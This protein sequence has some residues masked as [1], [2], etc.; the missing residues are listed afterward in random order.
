MQEKTILEIFNWTKLCQQRYKKKFKELLSFTNTSLFFLKINEIGKNI[1]IDFRIYLGGLR[2]TP[3][4]IASLFKN[5]PVP[6]KIN[7]N[8]N[9]IIHN[10]K[11]LLILETNNRTISEF[12]SALWCQIWILNRKEKIKRVHFQRI[13]LPFFD[14]EEK[15]SDYIDFGKNKINLL[16]LDKYLKNHF[17]LGLNLTQDIKNPNIKIKTKSVVFKDISLRMQLVKIEF[18]SGLYE[19][20][21]SKK[22]KQKSLKESYFSPNNL[23]FLKNYSNKNVMDTHNLKSIKRKIPIF[24]FLYKKN[25][26]ISKVN[27]KLSRKKNNNY[28]FKIQ[29]RLMFIKKEYNISFYSPKAS[30]VT[31]GEINLLKFT[32]KGELFLFEF[33][34]PF[35]FDVF[36][37]QQRLSFHLKF[38]VAF[39][40]ISSSFYSF[41]ASWNTQYLERILL[42]LAKFSKIKSSV[43]YLTSI[44]CYTNSFTLKKINYK[45]K[46]N[47]NLIRILKKNIHFNK[48]KSTWTQAGIEICS[49]S[50]KLMNIL[51]K[52]K[53]LTY[54]NLDFNFN[55]KPIR[56]LSTKE[57]KKSRFS[58]TFHFLREFLRFV[59]LIVDCH[60]K[61]YSGYIDFFQLLD[62]IHFILTH[63]GK[64]TGIYRYKYKIMK[65]IKICKN[66]KKILY[67]KFYEYPVSK[68][69]GF[70]F[71]SPV[72]KVWV[73]FIK[74]MV[75][76]Q[77]RWLANLLSRH[78]NGRKYSKKSF[79]ITKQRKDGY[80][81]VELKLAL[82]NELNNL[83]GN[84]YKKTNLKKYIK[85]SNEAWKSWKSNNNWNPIDLPD[86]IENLILDYVKTKSIWWVKSACLVRESL[87][88]GISMEKSKIKKNLG[89]I[90]RLWFKAEQKRQLD[91]LKNGPF[92]SKDELF[93]VSEIFC[94][95]I[96]ICQIKKINFPSFKNKWDL[97]LL[98]LSLDR[99]KKNSPS[100]KMD[101]KINSLE[102]NLLQT[103]MINP[104]GTFSGIKNSILTQRIFSEIG[105]AFMDGFSYLNPI[106]FIAFAERITDGYIDQYLWYDCS[107]KI[108]FPK[109]IKPSD[110]E[111][112]PY[113]I[114]KFQNIIEKQKEIENFSENHSLRIGKIEFGESSDICDLILMEKTLRK[115]LNYSL[116]SYICS[117]NNV[118]VVFKDMFE[119]NSMGILRG[120]QFGGFLIQI[121]YFVFDLMILGIKNSLQLFRNKVNDF[122]KKGSNLFTYY[123]RYISKTIFII[124]PF[125]FCHTKY[126]TIKMSFKIPLSMGSIN[127]SVIL[128]NKGLYQT[129]NKNISLGF[130][131]FSIFFI[132]SFKLI[133]D[134]K[135]M[136]E[137]EKY[138]NM[139][140]KI[141]KS[142]M[143]SL[144]LFQVEGRIRQIILNSGSTTFTKIANKWNS[145]ILGILTY[146]RE[147]SKKNRNCFSIL[148]KS[149]EK[150]QNRIKTS[151]NSKMP[152][153]FPLVLFFAPKELGGLGMLS[154]S[155]FLIPDN[156]LKH[157]KLGQINENLNSSFQS[158]ITSIPVIINFIKNWQ[159]EFED[160]KEIWSD[161]V[162]RRIF[163]KHQQRNLTFE[164]I[165]DLWNKGIP[166]INTLFQ[167]EREL[168]AFDYGWRLRTIMEKF[169]I[170]KINPFWWTV[171]NHDGRLWTLEFYKDEMIKN[172]GGITNILEHTLFK[173]TY[174]PTWE[175]LFWE[176]SS[177]FEET[178][179]NKK[180]THAQRSG[181][182]QI[183][184]RRFTLWWSPTI[185]RGNIYI[186]FQVQLDLTGVFMHGKIPTLKISLIQI[187]RAHLWQKIHQSITLDLCRSLEIDLDKLMISSIQKEQVHPRKSYKM[188]SSCADIIFVSKRSWKI[189]KPSLLTP[190]VSKFKSQCDIGNIFWVDIQLRWGDFDSHD[191]ER[192]VRGKF[193]DFTVYQNGLYPGK[194]GLIIGIDLSY[195]I[196]S[197]YGF[198]IFGL[199]QK[200]WTDLTKLMKSNSAL[201]ILRDRIR[202]GL[203]LYTS[204]FSESNLNSGNYFELFQSGNI[205][206]I[207]D[208]LFYRVT[209]HQTLIG[210]VKTKPINGVIIIFL[211]KNGNLILRIISSEIWKQQKRLS[212]LARWRA[213]EEIF[214]FL[215][216]ISI[217]DKPDQIILLRKTLIDPL[218]I[219]LIEY[220]NILIKF[221]NFKISFQS[222]LYFKKIT[223]RILGANECETVIFNL[224]DNW[225]DTVS[226][227]TAFSRLILILKGLEVDCKQIKQ[228]LGVGLEKNVKNFFWP[229]FTNEE[230]IT[231]EITLKDLIL[232]SFATKNKIDSASLFQTEI[233]DIIFGSYTKTPDLAKNEETCLQTVL[234]SDNTGKKITTTV[235]STILKNNGMIVSLK[236]IFY[237]IKEM[238]KLLK[239]IEIKKFNKKS[240]FEC[241]V[242]PRNLLKKL[243]FNPNIILT[244]ISIIFGKN[245]NSVSYVMEI[246]ILLLIPQKRKILK[247]IEWIP[248]RK[249]NIFKAV[250]FLG[251]VI[252]RERKANTKSIYNFP[253]RIL[254]FMQKIL[255]LK[256]N[257]LLVYIRIEEKKISL[258]CFKYQINLHF[259]T[260]TPILLTRKFFGLVI[261]ILNWN[262]L[263]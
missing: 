49:Q 134:I 114:N 222:L 174:F 70:G 9:L 77:E 48:V 195:N 242:F 27:L 122:S 212:Q 21:F 60:V 91:Y 7:E 261:N 138:R 236:K 120:L 46:M 126:L 229:F 88:K 34:K 57:R 254:N 151:F 253:L 123:N 83:K 221:S 181:L 52:R 136:N 216:T 128:D 66:I 177:G 215:K 205:W 55:L 80:L 98:I 14:D 142:K 209:V 183:P 186:G 71:W 147:F 31:I 239:K 214:K 26:E 81:D 93:F 4:S 69:P 24:D 84:I 112:N 234:T 37:S 54:L 162:R 247:R 117:K 96:K 220:P 167:K 65:Q 110:K 235:F 159:N 16:K 107:Q 63:I 125:E 119:L 158:P 202:K 199:G 87:N 190:N 3:L 23:I 8:L 176:K 240:D 56:T 259:L 99:I 228:I 164:D 118:N 250:K 108:L 153:R 227:F 258:K 17:K 208:T 95:W 255:I 78:L 124:S 33:I 75:P 61:F 232:E 25:S 106:Y 223:K 218:E 260:E 256:K 246:R 19:N 135:I 100:I 233:R 127:F 146:F 210:N 86:E 5:L 182:N 248:F 148:S 47:Y 45:H 11:S 38:Q 12:S 137:N 41:S 116:I 129:S 165:E 43:S 140:K 163:F 76:V 1:K 257:T 201:Y 150:I 64:I 244:T 51:I 166:R 30:F 50:Y 2:Y 145:S 203:Q 197:G 121:Y 180:L 131:G 262:N 224:Y 68:G 238:S 217:N 149:E 155:N 249:L 172:L 200:I 73:F 6:W 141:I 237:N 103:A 74:G 22:E 251:Y 263:I 44:K 245:S 154:I 36:F 85:E 243:I 15:F 213:A 178:L 192:Y 35:F 42:N 130:C 156:D 53:G 143:G 67:E 206:I 193:L 92:F 102:Q 10:T 104:I 207:D 79:S 204:R 115:I 113:F 40:E 133:R 13:N 157:K 82:I 161:F 211:P 231:L 20:V 132:E 144:V 72:W 32:D 171:R 175:G 101:W 18:Q 226:E 188:N 191:I 94:H 241:H 170:Q 105:L 187:F 194:H 169:Q 59:K 160:S 111:I 62:G 39:V 58:N 97:K 90:T 152:S 89:K 184:N 28:Y 139:K 185:N 179:E 252:K 196:F 219:Q 189:F 29:S 225:I 109:W 230:W 168:L 198:E 173:G